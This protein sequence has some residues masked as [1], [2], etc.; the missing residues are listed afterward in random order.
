MFPQINAIW[1]GIIKF[2][3]LAKTTNWRTRY[4][5][6]VATGIPIFTGPVSDWNILQVEFISWCAFY[7]SIYTDYERPDNKT[8][9]DDQLL[10]EWLR[11]R[12]NER[13]KEDIK[14]KQDELKTNTGSSN[15]FKSETFEF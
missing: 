2:R 4:D 11:K 10:D 3:S 15:N 1:G 13:R 5:L 12:N 8:I 7:H 9:E 14:R 6:S